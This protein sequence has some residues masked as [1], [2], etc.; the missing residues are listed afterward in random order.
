FSGFAFTSWPSSRMAAVSAGERSAIEQRS[1]PASDA[2]RPASC[3]RTASALL[4][5]VCSSFGMSVLAGC[6]RAVLGENCVKGGD[7]FVDML[8]AKNVGRQEAQHRLAGTVDQNAVLQ[9]LC[10][11][12]FR[13]IRGVELRGQHQAETTHFCNGCVLLLQVFELAAEVITDFVDVIE[14]VLLFNRV[15][16][17]NAYGTSQWSAAESCSVHAGMNRLRCFIRAEQNAQ[18]Q[19]AGNRLGQRRNVRLNIVVLIC[20]PFAGAAETCLNFVG[21]QQ[22]AGGL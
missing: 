20:K 10:Q 15:K 11:N 3:S 21:N 19:S 7:G 12:R 8:L 5:N 17:S 14:Q 4:A 6:C 9:H 22:R 16:D 1:R 2:P 18:R 13:Q